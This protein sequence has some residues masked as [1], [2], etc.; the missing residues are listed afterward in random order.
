MEKTLMQA[1]QDAEKVKPFAELNGKP[2]VTFEGYSDLVSRDH[3][4]KTVPG[5]VPVDERG[6]PVASLTPYVAMNPEVMFMN[7]FRVVKDKGKQVLQ[8]VIDRRAIDEQSRGM[9]YKSHLPAVCLVRDD[10]GELVYDKTVLI[11]DK[12]FLS[13][14]TRHLDQETMSIIAPLLVG[15][16]DPTADSLPI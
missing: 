6:L 15:G 4:M 12:E 2:V 1:I 3:Y 7:R 16:E 8:V 14:F 10:S 11:S 13:E 9:V 5:I